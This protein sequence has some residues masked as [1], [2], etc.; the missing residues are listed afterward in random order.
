MQ[1]AFAMLYDSSDA[2]VFMNGQR[3]L[4]SC[5]TAVLKW[6]HLVWASL[7]ND[8]N[9]NRLFMRKFQLCRNDWKKW[10]KILFWSPRQS[11]ICH[12]TAVGIH[13]HIGRLL[14]FCVTASEEM[15]AVK[16]A[17]DS[18]QVWW[19][20]N[21]TKFSFHFIFS[22]WIW[23]VWTYAIQYNHHHHNHHKKDFFVSS[24]LRIYNMIPCGQLMDAGPLV[25]CG[26]FEA[27]I[28]TSVLFVTDQTHQGNWDKLC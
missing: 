1:F 7:A 23:L 4:L 27:R 12:Q 5:H 8:F 20:S 25:C 15:W 22:I 17:L 14:H 21:L 18:Q 28:S 10:R 3:Y 2:V 16:I 24:C 9:L 26:W 13:C 11:C 19:F 6:T